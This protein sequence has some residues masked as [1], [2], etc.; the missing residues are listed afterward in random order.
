MIAL[1][2]LSIAS[3]AKE[4]PRRVRDFLLPAW[5]LMHQGTSTTTLECPSPTY[6]SLRSA[7]VRTELVLLRILKFELRISTPFDFLPGYLGEAMGD[8]G[9]Y[10]GCADA[11]VAFDN[12]SKEKKE[13]NRIADL[14]ETGIAKDCKAR[15]L[16]AYVKKLCGGRSCTD[17]CVDARI[18]SLRITSLTRPSLLR[19]STPS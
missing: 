6:D 1:A 8:F 16:D 11:D 7:F 18:T 14:M 15:T 19:A 12:R 5:R 17:L 4:S 2:C 10:D 13:A 9:G 3:K